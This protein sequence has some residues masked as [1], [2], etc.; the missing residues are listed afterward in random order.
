MWYTRYS[1]RI[2]VEI[3]FSGEI[4]KKS[5]NIKFQENSSIWSRVVPCERTRDSHDETNSRFSQIC[6]SAYNHLNVPHIAM[7]C[8]PAIIAWEEIWRQFKIIAM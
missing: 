8:R 7:I 5:P 1:C 4:F 2:L 3:E 6:E